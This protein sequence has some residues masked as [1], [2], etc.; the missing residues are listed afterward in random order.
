[1]IIN[2]VFVWRY[3]TTRYTDDDFPRHYVE[4]IF[5]FL[6]GVTFAKKVEVATR[7]GRAFMACFRTTSTPYQTK[8]L[9]VL[10]R[11]DSA[12][13]LICRRDESINN[14]G[15]LGPSLKEM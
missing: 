12:D 1:M 6:T 15:K 10:K 2:Y 13:R 7:K 9:A 8:L 11:D 4:L 3:P 5:K 14:F